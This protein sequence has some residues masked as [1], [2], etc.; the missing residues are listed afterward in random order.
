MHQDSLG[1]NSD[2]DSGVSLNIYNYTYIRTNCYFQDQNSS[3][4]NSLSSPIMIAPPLSLNEKQSSSHLPTI[5]EQDVHKMQAAARGGGD[6]GGGGGGGRISERKAKHFNIQRG[7]LL[8]VCVCV[9]AWV[10][11]CMCVCVCMHAC[12]VCVHACVRACMRVCTCVRMYVCMISPYS[13]YTYVHMYI[14][15]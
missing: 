2:E 3:E 1:L 9:R 14:L 11:V 10:C 13:G 6:W 8:G 15:T 7:K 4:E 5:R 12:R